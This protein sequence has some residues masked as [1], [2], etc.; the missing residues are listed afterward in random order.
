MVP[1]GVPAMSE[2]TE[3]WV[4]NVG[5]H[6]WHMEHEGSDLDLFRCYVT[7][8]EDI[9]S[10]K[11][12]P[13]GTHFS[14]TGEGA[15]RVDLQS[16]EVGAWVEQLLK[17]NPNYLFGLLSPLAVRELRERYRRELRRIIEDGL[18]RQLYFPVRGLI[19]SNQRKYITNGVDPSERRINKL[20]RV[21]RWGCW[22]L[23]FASPLRF[24]PYEGGKPDDVD[25]MLAGL[26]EA[27][28][29]SPLPER[30]TEKTVR[31]ARMWLLQVRLA[32]MDEAL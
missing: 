16:H 3:L 29:Q 30:V 11:T 22:A 15:E 19:L 25:V 1:S 26:K 18:S 13:G 28:E 2:E 5:S 20:L 24:D 10:G 14:Q 31:A 8:T 4:T 6:L 32:E 21:G 12:A 7:P 23:R 17:M 27:Y 9:L